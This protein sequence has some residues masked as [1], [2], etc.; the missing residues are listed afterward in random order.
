MGLTPYWG[1]KVANAF[2]ADSPGVYARDK[3]SNLGTMN[4]IH[5]E[6][7]IIDGS[8]VD[9]LRQSKTR[10]FV[11]DQPSG[12]KVY[13]P[14]ETNHYKKNELFCFQFKNILFRR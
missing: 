2:H 7:N 5:L 12:Y 9:G 1:Y 6:T 3:I 13:C 10:S 8:I 4:K 14:P 11:L